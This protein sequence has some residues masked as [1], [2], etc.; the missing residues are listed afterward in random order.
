MSQKPQ[1][2]TITDSVESRVAKL[3]DILGLAYTH[4]DQNCHEPPLD[5][6]LV[7]SGVFIEAKAYHAERTGRQLASARNVILFQG[8]GAVDVLI[9]AVD[10]LLRTRNMQEDLVEY[11]SYIK[12]LKEFERSDGKL[13][14]SIKGISDSAVAIAAA[15]AV[16]ELID[17]KYAEIKLKLEAE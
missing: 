1:P 12:I 6:R 7:E 15:E 10:K 4:E 11:R 13:L 8:E 2:G 9:E 14:S 3:L 5:F 17:K 16:S